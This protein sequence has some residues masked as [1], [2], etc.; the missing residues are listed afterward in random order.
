M[1]DDHSVVLHELQ[2]VVIV[3]N[4]SAWFWFCFRSSELGWG[5]RAVI[6]LHALGVRHTGGAFTGLGLQSGEG[7]GEWPT[8]TAIRHGLS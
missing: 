5:L 7:D 8:P 6:Q 1:T 3:C 4:V 2:F